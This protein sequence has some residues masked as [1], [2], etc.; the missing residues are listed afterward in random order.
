M[1]VIDITMVQQN[2]A[3]LIE[4]AA[5]GNEVIIT[6]PDG[7]DVRLIP[8]ATGTPQFGSACGKIRLHADFDD[9]LADGMQDA[10]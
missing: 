9:P 4:A 1:M 2:L 10:A 8:V 6:R 3:E 5:Q 7:S